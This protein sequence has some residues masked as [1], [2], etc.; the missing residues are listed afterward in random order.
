MVL[1]SEENPRV[2]RSPRFEPRVWTAHRTHRST[3]R[4]R[5]FYGS[6]SVKQTLGSKI[7]RCARQILARLQFRD[8]LLQLTFGI[9]VDMAVA[10][11][12]FDGGALALDPV[13]EKGQTLSW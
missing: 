11:E 5:A 13:P 3:L 6:R 8:H 1:R 10:L 2:M 7:S 4:E 12:G 9:G